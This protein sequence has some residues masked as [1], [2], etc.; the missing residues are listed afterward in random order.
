MEQKSTVTLDGANATLVI[1]GELLP[2][3]EMVHHI[4]SALLDKD[5]PP[6]AKI[7][8]KKERNV[9]TYKVTFSH[10]KD[11]LAE[12]KAELDIVT[13]ARNRNMSVDAVR[14]QKKAQAEIAAKEA[15][16]KPTQASVDEAVRKA[17]EQAK[18]P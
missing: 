16:K 2:E 15:K 13:E 6:D 4:L 7:E 17:Q 12:G 11:V 9:I 14:A 18:K 10:S 1:A 8:F 3:N 5:D